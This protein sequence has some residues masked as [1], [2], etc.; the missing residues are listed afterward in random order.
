MNNIQKY[1]IEGEKLKLINQEDEK[2]VIFDFPIR[3]VVQFRNCYVV[4]IEPSVGEIYNENVF[5]ISKEGRIL[6]QIEPIAHIYEDSP[7]TGI[8]QVNDSVKLSNWDGTDLTVN[9]ATGDVIQK[10]FSK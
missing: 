6:W 10:S 9:P 8:G 4:R 1:L 5:G 2:I 3:Q 7:Y